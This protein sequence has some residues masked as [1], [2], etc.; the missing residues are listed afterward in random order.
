MLDAAAVRAEIDR[1]D[2]EAPIEDAWT[3]P[4]SWYVDPAFDALDRRA[5]FGAS[6]QP[7]AR[8]A[9]VREPGQYASGCTAGEPWVVVRGE[10][11]ALRAFSNT[12]RHKGREVVQ[13]AGR[14]DALVCGYHAW[15]YG[16]DG[17]LRKAPRVGG[18]RGFER[19]QMS[20]PELAVD[21][22][23][24]WVFVHHDPGAPPVGAGL[25]PLTSRLDA[26]GWGALR[27]VRSTS[28][29]LECNW[30]VV[31][32]NYLDGG[33]HIPHMHPSLDAQLD[34]ATYRTE[35]FERASIQSSAP[36][37]GVG[38]TAGGALYA[39][40]HPGFMINR[41]G[42]CLD[43]NRVVPLG[44]ERC[45]VDYDFFFRACEGAAAASDIERSV[46]QSAVTQREDI[47]ICE[48][49]QVGLRSRHYDRGRYAPR[50]EVGE[51]RFH[52][53]LAA[54]YRRHL[55]AGRPAGAAAG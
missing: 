41:Y 9:E 8:L 13:G 39:W 42:D 2:A 49:V 32:D 25:E 16:L 43:T 15:S 21:T 45:R 28:W 51:L 27:Y 55:R 14:A 17:T 38:R 11:G 35:C 3:P 44:P 50:L 26:T 12:C 18:I 54:D 22:W 7:V 47:A 29:T 52:R 20:L 37:P 1:F 19:A 48:S 23:G 24:P 30:K 10:D 5:V 36:G 40:I 34:L 6:W 46:A 53:L 33:Y 4:A 31:V